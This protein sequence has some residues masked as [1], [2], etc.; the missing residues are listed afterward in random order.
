MMKNTQEFKH[1]SILLAVDG[2]P[3]AKAAAYAATQVASTLN[4]NIHALYV[5]DAVQVFETYSDPRKELGKLEGEISNERLITLFEEQGM[6]TLAEID[7]L[8]QEMNV[9]ITTEILFGGVPETILEVSKQFSLLALGRKGNHHDKDSHHL[10][11]NFQRIAH[12]TRTPLL[13]SSDAD[14]P[15]QHQRVLL[16][17]DG[18][19]LSHTALLW[20][21]KLQRMFADVMALSVEKNSENDYV[22]LEQRQREIADSSLENYEFDQEVGEPEKIIPS[23]ATSRHADL[24]VM[25]AYQHSQI[26]EWATHSILSSVMR[27]VRIPI[28]AAK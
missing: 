10:G 5:V 7:E 12:H 18:S 21:E 11:W 26:L 14:T 25:G 16:A 8:C 1:D 28:L 17:Y 20:T 19:E 22:W 3:S 23:V 27:N 2:S 15:L 6:L 4:W 9:P 13:I 24:I